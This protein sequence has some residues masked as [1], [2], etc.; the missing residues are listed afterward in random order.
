MLAVAAKT[1]AVSSRFEQSPTEVNGMVLVGFAGFVDPI[2]STAAAAV[3]QLGAAGVSMKVLT[4]D[5]PKVAEYSA[6]WPGTSQPHR[7]RRRHGQAVG[8]PSRRNCL[9]ENSIRQMDPQ[10]KAR[11]VTALRAGGHTVGFIGDGI[12]DSSAL[13]V[14]DVGSVSIRRPKSPGM[15]RI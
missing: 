9:P 13:R 14:A 2:K 8:F 12:N 4:G 5:A 15:R 3:R 7:D 6:R 1:I 10:Q 11:I